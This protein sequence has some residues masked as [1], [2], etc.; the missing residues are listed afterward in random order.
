MCTYVAAPAT[1]R[2]LSEM[3]A[4]VIKIESFA[5]D[6]QHPGP[7]LRLRADRYKIPPSI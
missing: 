1:V 4:E 2:V 3:G 7:R 5:G 6:T